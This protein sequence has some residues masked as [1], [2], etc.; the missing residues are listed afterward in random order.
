MVAQSAAIRFTGVPWTVPSSLR[1]CVVSNY[2]PPHFL[3]GYELGCRDIVEALKSRGHQV[4]V[5]TSTYK[6]ETP[7][8]DGQVYRR[9]RIGDWWTPNSLGG[10]RAVLKKEIANRKA[11]R[12]LCSDFYPYLIYVWNPVGLSLSL[13][14]ELD[15][16][17]CYFVSDHWL[18]DWE[19]DSGYQ[20]WQQQQRHPLWKAILSLAL[21]LNVIHRPSSPNLRY[22][23]FAS[24]FLKQEA[25]SKGKPVSDAAVIHWGVDLEKYHYRET[26][27]CSERLLYVGHIAPHKGVHTVIEALKLLVQAGHKEATLTIA[28]GSIVPEYEAQVRQMVSSFQL[29]EQ[30]RFTGQLSRERL[31]SIYQEHDVLIFPSIWDEPFSITVVEAMASGL[32]V[33]GTPTGGSK[34]IFVDDVNALVFPKEDA[35]ACAAG[36]RRLFTDERLFQEIRRR[37]RDTV[38][39]RFQL[40]QMVDTIERS[41]I[42]AVS[43]SFNTSEDAV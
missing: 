3:G 28:G 17:V 10:L 8:D 18:A 13:V 21:K 1:I 5:L 27:K 36:I 31:P 40:E 7:Q 26:S 41:L 25:L 23:Q 4:K 39:R 35:E 6:V 2:Y 32:A 14:S 16:P 24:D 20:M 12:Q 33:V 38:E 34:E 29:D 30:V 37:G 9:L 11:F 42:E 19:A 43:N 22:V 15:L